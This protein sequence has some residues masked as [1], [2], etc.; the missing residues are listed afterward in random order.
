MLCDARTHKA[1]AS[2]DFKF[3]KLHFQVDP[4][5]NFISGSVTYYFIASSTD[6][7]QLNLS[8]NMSIDSIVYHHQNILGY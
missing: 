5:V 1:N 8:A 6:T 7:L 4:H 3:A 2:E